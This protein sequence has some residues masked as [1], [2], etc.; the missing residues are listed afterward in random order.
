MVKRQNQGKAVAINGKYFSNLLRQKRGWRGQDRERSA[1]NATRK[2]QD[3]SAIAH[4]EVN[5]FSRVQNVALVPA[6]IAWPLA[7][8]SN[9]QLKPAGGFKMAAGSF[10]TIIPLP[11]SK[12]NLQRQLKC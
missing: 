12:D 8:S 1:C 2:S 4:K 6:T 9:R 7:Y 11:I 3:H 10:S 5:S